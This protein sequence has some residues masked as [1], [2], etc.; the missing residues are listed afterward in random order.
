MVKLLW[1]IILIMQLVLPV[2]ASSEKIYAWRNE[3]GILVY[4]DTPVPGAK[5]VILNKKVNRYNTKADTSILAIK[6]PERAIK[7]HIQINQPLQDATIRDNA[8]NVSISASV[9]PGLK[10]GLTIQLLLNRSIYKQPQTKTTFE[11]HN[12]DRGEHQI[13]VQL[14]SK[15][16][17]VI[18]TSESVRFYM[19]RNAV[20]S[21][22]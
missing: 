12:I 13:K 8:G 18:A 4:S 16:G 1:F 21:N 22:N 14:L 9:M 17:K 19:R 2:L 11:L 15:K 5:Q 3:Q 20:G 10:N 7:H 6:Q